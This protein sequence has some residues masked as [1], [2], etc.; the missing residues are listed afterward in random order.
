MPQISSFFGR[1][2]VLNI[3]FRFTGTLLFIYGIYLF[4]YLL[5]FTYCIQHCFICRPSDST[6][7]TDAGIE[8]R[9]VATG[10]LTVRRS[11]H[12]ARSHPYIYLFINPPKCC[13]VL[14][15]IAGCYN[16][17]DLLL[18]SRSPKERCILSVTFFG[19]WF[20]EK[21]AEEV[22]RLEVFLYEADQNF[23]H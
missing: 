6:V 2:L 12:E 14:V 9:T 19:D 17:S 10:A 20:I 5:F 1:R 4:I 8:P 23:E 18:T 7:T 16:S 11:N 15:R 13:I 3:F 22:G 21:R